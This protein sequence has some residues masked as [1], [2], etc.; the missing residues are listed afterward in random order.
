MPFQLQ[1]NHI[2]YQDEQPQFFVVRGSDLKKFGP[3]TL[4]GPDLRWY[5][6]KSH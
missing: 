3:V 6:I 4:T 5:L 2:G 1:I